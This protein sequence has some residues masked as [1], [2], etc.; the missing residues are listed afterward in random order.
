MSQ[1]N[2]KKRNPVRRKDPML[3]LLL[4]KD[5]LSA[6]QKHCAAKGITMSEMIRLMIYEK[7]YG[8]QGN[9][10]DHLI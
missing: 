8:D 3:T 6:F 10:I 9:E 5:L 7:V 2:K 1:P 4:N